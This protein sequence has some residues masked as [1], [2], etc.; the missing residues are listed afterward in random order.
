MLVCF[1][2][3]AAGLLQ[4]LIHLTNPLLDKHQRT[5]NNAAKFVFQRQKKKTMQHPYMSLTASQSKLA[6]IT[7]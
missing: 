6:L 7:S 3:V 4:L 1:L 5:Q 2:V